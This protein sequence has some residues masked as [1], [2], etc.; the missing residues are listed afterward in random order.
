LAEKTKDK[1]QMTNKT[2]IQNLM[3]QKN[4]V[5]WYLLF[6]ISGLSGLGITN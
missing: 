2:Q 6:V 3:L 1:S 4:F 5:F